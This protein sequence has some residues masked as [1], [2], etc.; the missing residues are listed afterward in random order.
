MKSAWLVN[1]TRFW[2]RWEAR[3]MPAS[4]R[5]GDRLTFWRERILFTICFTSSTLGLCVLVPS[6]ALALAEGRTNVVLLD[7][8]AYACAVVLLFGGRLPFTLRAAGA[9]LLLYGLGIGLMLMLGPGGAGIAWLFTASVMVAAMLGF[10]AAVGSLMLNLATLVVMGAM[11][12]WGRPTWPLPAEN[13]LEIWWVLTINFM[14]CNTLV[15][16]ATALMLSD[17]KRSLLHEQDVSASLRESELRYRT[18][19][20][21]FPNGALSLIDRDLRFMAIDGLGLGAYGLSGEALVGRRIDT[22]L[23][24]VADIVVAECRRVLAGESR[25]F[26][27]DYHARCFENEAIPVTGR[28]G[29]IDGALVITQDVTER[30]KAEASL[31]MSEK[32]FRTLVEKAPLGI[33]TVDRRG[34]IVDAN[35]KFTAIFGFRSRESVLRQNLIHGQR[36]RLAGLPD[37]IADCLANGTAGAYE[38]PPADGQAPERFLRYLLSPL[39]DADGDIYAVLGLF[40]DITTE[41]RQAER[42]RRAQ[43]MEALGLLAGGVA[44]DLNNVLSGIV[45]YPEL[46]LLDL[47]GDSPL[48]GPVQTI[49][50]SGQKAAEIVQDLLTLA[51]RGVVSIAVVNLNQMVR[52]YL[53]SP[54]FEKLTAYH[55]DVS[56]EMQLAPDLLNLSGSAVQLKKTIMNLI[57]NAAEAQPKGGR[58][59]VSTENHYADR[60]IQDEDRLREGDY[61]VLRVADEGIGISPEDHRRI[62]EPF[63]S[64]KMMGRSGTGLGMAVVWA[65][66][67]DHQGTIE[68]RS[69]EGAGTTFNL[70]FPATRQATAAVREPLPIADLM[71]SGAS[72]LVVDDVEEQRMIANGI[73]E[74]LGYRPVCVESGAAAVAYL[75]RQ[76]ADLVLLDMI[77]D[78]GMDGLETYRRIIDIH[79][80]QK[81]VIASGFAETARVKAALALGVANYLK[82]PYTIE[83]IGRAVKQ[84][85]T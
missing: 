40:E 34:D 35:N 2:F 41:R 28:E 37:R 53:D 16:L 82:K 24:D 4:A 7:L 78:P 22:A 21:N 26:T 63:Y 83:K 17:M 27:F 64:K 50:R 51:R 39:R 45:S 84:A 68:V 58:I 18:L 12:A 74:R 15:S 29:G 75:E 52:E 81:A 76:R 70:Y 69:A 36:I 3:F 56:V 67:Q 54:E 55:P 25:R 85:L 38:A 31:R 77:M 9:C 44:H 62:F 14:L 60:P 11:I 61:V 43:K 6:L 32:R 49:Q 80:G 42:L 79:P 30:R 23:P 48:R 66:V 1:I 19:A 73:L 33:I 13:A 20:R 10:R 5:Y 72:V 65:T 46:L 71:G 8:A 47:P 57:S 59:V